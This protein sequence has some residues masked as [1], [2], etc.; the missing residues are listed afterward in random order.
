MGNFN[1]NEDKIQEAYE[2][3]IA[4]KLIPYDGKHI[5]HS[6]SISH[7]KGIYGNTYSIV[8]SPS[9]QSW[10]VTGKVGNEWVPVTP[11]FPDKESAV[12]F[13]NWLDAAGKDQQQMVGTI[14]GGER[15]REEKG[16]FIKAIKLNNKKVSMYR[17]EKKLT[18][19]VDLYIDDK[20][21]GEYP[22]EK[23]AM[24]AAEEKVNEDSS[25][26]GV[27]NAKPE[28]KVEESTGSYLHGLFERLL[29]E[30][31][32]ITLGKGM[33][34]PKTIIL[35]KKETEKLYKLWQKELK[36]SGLIGW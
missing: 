5:P 19:K 3:A 33:V 1:P 23:A 32:K 20:K 7:I 30:L 2:K 35:L 27:A 34:P 15:L 36:G 11:G 13:K 8:Q 16:F 26:Y 29:E 14:D 4:E 21:V 6:S 12:K 10:Y 22:G 18:S 17:Q 31:D 28:E 9:T 25:I 24:K